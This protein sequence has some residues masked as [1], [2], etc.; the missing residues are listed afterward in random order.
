M[1]AGDVETDNVQKN[2]LTFIKQSR[3][4]SRKLHLFSLLNTNQRL[5]VKD[6][7]KTTAGMLIMPSNCHCVI[8]SHILIVSLSFQ[9]RCQDFS[10]EQTQFPEHV[11]T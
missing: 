9:Y 7:Q 11:K 2:R 4:R 1:A 10:S 3:S 6:Q 5:G 8:V